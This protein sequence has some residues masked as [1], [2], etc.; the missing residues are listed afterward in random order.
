METLSA[1]PTL[2]EGNIPVTGGFH[3]QNPH[4]KEF[5]VIYVFE[6]TK[7][8]NKQLNNRFLIAIVPNLQTHM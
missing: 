5:D 2:W 1:L 6:L 4:K 7:L 8:F 3:S